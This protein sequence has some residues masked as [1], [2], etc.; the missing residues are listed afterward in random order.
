MRII[1]LDNYLKD[2]LLKM[3]EG[4][5]FSCLNTSKSHYFLNDKIELLRRE[6]SSQK[7][8]NFTK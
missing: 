4:S 3:D 8:F 5:N 1:F 7:N 6:K 2:L